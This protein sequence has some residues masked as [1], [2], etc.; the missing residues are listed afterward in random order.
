MIVL[1]DR[2]NFRAYGEY[3][4]IC[5]ILCHQTIRIGSLVE[6][7]IAIFRGR[8]FIDQHCNQ[9]KAPTSYRNLRIDVE[10]H[11]VYRGEEVIDLTRRI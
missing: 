11:M 10:N 4:T 1:N 3:P 2:E 7:I 6:K 9:M 8:D 5:S